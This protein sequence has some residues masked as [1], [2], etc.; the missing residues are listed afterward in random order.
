MEEILRK[1]YRSLLAFG[2]L[3]MLTMACGL[4]FLM[5]ESPPTPPSESQ[6]ST[7]VAL[8]FQAL[9]PTVTPVS[10][11]LPRTLYY[12]G[13]DEAGLTQVYRLERDGRTVTRVTY[14]PLPVGN[15]GV[16]PVDGSVA[17]VAN[18]QLVL[19]NADNSGR[20]VLVDGGAVDENNAFL[21]RITNPVFSPDGQILAYGYKGLNFYSLS[22]GVNNL[23]IQDQVRDLG[24]GMMFPTELYWP[25][26]YSP[27]GSKL[28]IT[29]GYYEGAEAAFYDV[30]S[31][32]LTR[33]K[34]A[35]GALICCGG[36]LWSADGTKVHSGNAAAGM[37][38]PGLW[39]VDPSNGDVT[40]LLASNYDTN[41]FNLAKYPYLAP[42]NQLYFFYLASN[43]G[44]YSRT[45]LQLVRSAVD[46]VTGRTVIRAEK[47]DMMNEALWA[48]DA[49]FVIVAK[50]PTQ[51]VYQGGIPSIVYIDGGPD[52]QLTDF[53]QQM[54]WGP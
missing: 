11:L 27:D 48:P 35:P 32:S 4:P 7:A 12:L 1:P 45:P 54:S 13:P 6:V 8:T 49:S 51:D 52:V 24:N 10:A 46:G 3:T 25:E 19:I 18:N 34:D 33:L 28:M 31:K 14:E 42:D 50:A 29:L 23:V 36:A 20:R 2:I 17:F 39:Q 43:T 5:R 26:K 30:Q 47:F 37:F 53:A 40:T 44:E 15:Y 41:T 22:T 9:T 38:N 16:N 21:T